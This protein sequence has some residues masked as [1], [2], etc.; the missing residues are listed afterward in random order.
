MSGLIWRRIAP[1]RYATGRGWEVR[2]IG[3]GAW[4]LL[5]WHEERKEWLIFMDT[6]P[7][8]TQAMALADRLLR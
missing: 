8:K 3:P 7:T 6:I 4:S 1:G 2:R 5:R